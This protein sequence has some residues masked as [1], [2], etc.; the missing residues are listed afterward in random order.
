VEAKVELAPGVH[1]VKRA[2]PIRIASNVYLL[3][4][5]VKGLT[6][7]DTGMPGRADAILHHV[8]DLGYE[9]ADVQRIVLTH[10]H[11]D[12]AGSLA[13]LVARTG[14]RVLAHLDEALLVEG[15]R[16]PALAARGVVGRTMRTLT[17]LMGGR[18][19]A[20]DERLT[21]G[22]VIPVLSGLRVL[23][24]P[25]HTPGSICLHLPARGV[26]FTGDTL[27]TGWRGGVQ[28]PSPLFALDIQQARASARALAGLDFNVLAPGHGPP[29]AGK[30][31]KEVRRIYEKATHVRHAPL[32][33]S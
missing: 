22:D 23:H 2:T 17:P 19:T 6:L 21:H 28:G 9:P 10:Y 15:Q 27:L 24:T 1:W 13:V 3:V 18:P 26:L 20:V 29:I 33:T 25:G 14:A 7:I 11:M 5:E 4:D 30:A 32:P 16:P 12:H 31:G 8:A